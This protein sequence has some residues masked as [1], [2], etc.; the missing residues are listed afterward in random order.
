MVRVG[1]LTFS[2]CLAAQHAGPCATIVLGIKLLSQGVEVSEVI[3]QTRME[4][5]GIASS[6]VDSDAA[7]NEVLAIAKHVVQN[8]PA[9]TRKPPWQLI[10][11]V[12]GAQNPEAH[13]HTAVLQQIIAELP[14]REI[15][16]NKLAQVLRCCNVAWRNLIMVK[17]HRPIRAWLIVQS[18]EF[19]HCVAV[20]QGTSQETLGIGKMPDKVRVA[21]KRKRQL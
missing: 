18:D 11:H 6:D 14:K 9:Y 12:L 19:S 1:Q 3:G 21:R 17:D 20:L 7:S 16:A 5:D 10:Y 4:D 15:E 13:P 2:E 8:H